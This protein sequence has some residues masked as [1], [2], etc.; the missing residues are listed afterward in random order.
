M[1][2]WLRGLTGLRRRAGTERRHSW[3]RSPRSTTC[4][5]PAFRPV[6]ATTS[7]STWGSTVTT[8]SVPSMHSSMAGSGVS[9][10][11]RST[12]A[13]SSTTRRSGS[14]PKRCTE[15]GIR[16]AKLR[17]ILDTAPDVLGPRPSGTTSEL[18]WRG[19][20]G[21]GHESAAMI[22]VSNNPYR[23][24]RAVGPGTRPRIDRGELGVAVL[25]APQQQSSVARKRAAAGSSGRRLPS[26]SP[27]PNRCPSASTGRRSF[28][29]H[30][31]GFVMSAGCAAGAH[32]AAAPRRFTVGHGARGA[33]PGARTTVGSGGRAGL[34]H[35]PGNA[36]ERR[37]AVLSSRSDS[38][39]SVSGAAAGGADA[40]RALGGVLGEPTGGV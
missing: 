19:P 28:W 26:R 10:W 3:P 14:T 1:R 8:W 17:T 30:R 6:P 5:S 24:G 18:G 21:T 16:D 35:C 7:R 2:L 15:R 25:K 29:I 13:F 12:V 32:R 38:P 27:R 23:L 31:F 36:F 34:R 11:P 40:K 22:L 20:D 4:R 39:W 9:T 33:P 37:Q